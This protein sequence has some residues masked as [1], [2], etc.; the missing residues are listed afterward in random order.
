MTNVC[1]DL[2]NLPNYL[3]P[4]GVARTIFFINISVAFPQ[5]VYMVCKFLEHECC[6][7]LEVHLFS[8]V[9]RVHRVAHSSFYA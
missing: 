4:E 5:T 1:L 8:F 6:Y 2:V 9:S 3:E 7:F